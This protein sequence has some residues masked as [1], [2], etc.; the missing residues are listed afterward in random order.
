MKNKKIA[1]YG[2]AFSP[3]HL[4]HASVME[5]VLRLFPCDE[6]WVMPSTNRHD[7]KVSA[8]GSDRL[9]MLEILIQELFP[10]SK[11]PIIISD[12]ELQMDKPTVT[13]ETLKALDEK[14]PDN[15]FYFVLGSENLEVIETKW[16]NG[17]KLLQEANFIAIK[18]PLIPLSNKLP[19]NI[20]ILDDLPWTKIS[21]TFVRKLIAQGQSGLPYISKGVAEYIKGHNLY[22]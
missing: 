16:I 6:I 11:I 21:S 19:S 2:G 1:L 10:S 9:K 20:T 7:K 4:G 18:N 15:K 14:Y 13:Y 12:F 22:K 8:S 17:K 3:P 5:A